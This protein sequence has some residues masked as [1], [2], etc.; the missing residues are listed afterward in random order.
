MGAGVAVTVT[1]TLHVARSAVRRRPVLM[2]RT[3]AVGHGARHAVHLRAEDLY[4]SQSAAT[5]NAVSLSVDAKLAAAL[6][7]LKEERRRR[8]RAEEAVGAI[9]QEAESAAR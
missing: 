1:R 2:G 3:P 4:E 6:A 8:T 9:R 7:E 5:V